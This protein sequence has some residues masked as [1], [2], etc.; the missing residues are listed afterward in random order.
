[1]K[2]RMIFLMGLLMACMVWGQQRFLPE[3]PRLLFLE[4]E[5]SEVK[6]LMKTNKEVRQLADFLKAKA[7]S[8]T[9]VPQLQYGLDPYGQTLHLSRAYVLR[10]GTLALAYRLYGEKKYVDAVNESVLNVCAYPNWN[11]HGYNYLDTSEMATA[12]AI[13]YDW[14]YDVLPETT[15]RKVRECLYERAVSHVLREYEKGGAGSWVKR[16]TNWNVVC[17]AGMTMAVLAMAEDYPKETTVILDN[18]AKYMPNCLKHFAPDGV[19][20]EGPAYWGYTV[21]YLSLYLKA[22]ADNDGGKGGIDRLEGLDKTALYSKR[23]L[24][25]SGRIFNFA[26]ASK[27][28]LNTPAYFF[29]SR[30]YGQPEVAAWYREEIGRVIRNDMPLNQLFF[31]SLPWF[32]PAVSDGR[33]KGIPTLEVYHN[34]IN[35]IVVFNGN[36]KK[37]GALFLIAKGGE[38]RQAH[39][40]MDCG[41]FLVESEGICWTEDLGSEDYNVPGF[42]DGRVGGER[43]KYFRNNNFSH[44]TLNI[45]HQVQNAAGE[46]FVCEE[47]PDAD[48][49]YVRL[50]MTSLYKDQ[51]KATFRK[52]TLLDDR[53]M[54][55][56]DDVE[57]LDT[58]SVVYWTAVTQA[59]VEVDGNKAILC[60]DGKRFYLEIVSPDNAVFRTEQAKNMFKG[61]KPIEG[62]TI[63][64]AACQLDDGNGKIVVRMSS[65]KF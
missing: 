1:M 60:R 3:H 47:R 58:H 57:L 28:P 2:K 38:P 52:F 63:L 26:N 25:P 46:A 30:H 49:P 23:T 55:V 39:Q 18:A 13:A 10:L 56:E 4:S 12:V 6:E 19:C 32:D 36:R 50:D 65:R 16:N 8:I 51:A 64:E 9:E 48:Q 43:W 54:E 5:E 27:D 42:W 59:Q 44:N 31:L 17:N 11:P 24:T 14:L 53:T 20:Y 41:T 34:T 37:K 7:D 35:D 62:I 45:D 15:K 22:V 40:Q 29:F 61:E 21:T 33:Q